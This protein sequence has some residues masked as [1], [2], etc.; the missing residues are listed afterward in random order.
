V[1]KLRTRSIRFALAV[2]AAGCLAAQD[3]PDHQPAAQNKE[4]T[5][6]GSE[7]I[8]AFIAT[9]DAKRAVVFYRDTLGLRLVRTE[10]IA[11]V[12]DAN[13]VMLRVQIVS[14]VSVAP[15]TVLGWNVA[16]IAGTVRKLERA[17]VALLRIP[18]V[19]QDVLGIWKAPDG[20]RV[21]WFKD[22]DGHILSVAQ[23]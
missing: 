9:K 7:K 22:P 11:L 2:L 14:N 12:F 10:P 1:R 19:E 23:F 5:A 4:A 8:A 6:L 13:G 20:T 18:G 21:A 16:D 3:H 15:Y 17:G